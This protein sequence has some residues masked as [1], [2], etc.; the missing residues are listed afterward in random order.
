MIT[1]IGK[2]NINFNKIISYFESTDT[3][4]YSTYVDDQWIA[5]QKNKFVEHT[6]SDQQ[7][8]SWFNYN[9]TST[10]MEYL[11]SNDV[12]KKYIETC[13]PQDLLDEQCLD[14]NIA[15]WNIQKQSPGN[16]TV[17]HYDVYHSILSKD[18]DCKINQ[19]TRFWIPLEDAKF[20]HALF[21]EDTVLSDFK[22]GEIY[23]WGI[24][25]L[26]AAVNVGFD[27][28]YTLLLYFKK[29]IL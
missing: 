26:H 25:D 12:V 3:N 28:R 8:N 23:D 11:L 29:K 2:L 16:F 19:I 5:K 18:S 7:I 27:P 10:D 20:G 13:L 4:V 1:K 21:V 15:S 24:D 22:A 6:F 9:K 14:R 17:P